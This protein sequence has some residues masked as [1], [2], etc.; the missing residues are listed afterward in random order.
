MVPCLGADV[1]L[2]VRP[3]VAL[4]PVTAGELKPE[5]VG[6]MSMAFRGARS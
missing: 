3:V 6:R 2:S 5:L 4:V 1:K